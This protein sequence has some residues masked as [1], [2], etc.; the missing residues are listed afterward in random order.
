MIPV[1]LHSNLFGYPQQGAKIFNDPI[2]GHIEMPLYCV[3][4]IDTPQFQRLRD[5]KQLGII[6]LR[7]F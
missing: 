1:Q 2:H 6:N 4:I 7:N 5:L 3:S